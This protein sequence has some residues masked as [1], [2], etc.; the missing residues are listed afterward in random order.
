MMVPPL[1][2]PPSSW[3]DPRR[4]MV[5]FRKRREFLD[6]VTWC[7]EEPGIEPR[8]RLLAGP[9]GTGKTRTALEL[10][11]E[12]QPHGWIVHLLEEPY[13]AI[14]VV[15]QSIG[16]CTKPCL[17]I[18][19]NAD[20]SPSS[21]RRV[22]EALSEQGDT[23][24]R[25]LLIAR[26]AAV[27]WE[28]LTV[29]GPGAELLDPHPI[30][31]RHL[32]AEYAT[33]MARAA[34]SAVTAGLGREVAVERAPTPVA[35]DRSTS[36]LHA[37]TSGVV[38]ALGPTRT[39]GPAE[40]LRLADPIDALLTL[41]RR[42]LTKSAA[43]RHVTLPDDPAA[44]DLLL[45]VAWLTPRRD[46][47]LAVTLPYRIENSLLHVD[48]LARL[49]AE[50]YPDAGPR[51]HDFE[52]SLLRER[53]LE[54]LL[55]TSPHPHT[56]Q[57]IMQTLA[58]DRRHA[59]ARAVTLLS[60]LLLHQETAPPAR[61]IADMGELIRA[62]P[63][64]VVAAAVEVAVANP[65]TSRIR[66]HITLLLRS[67]P[68]HSLLALDSTIDSL[69]RTHPPAAMT[70]VQQLT[71]AWETTGIGSEPSDRPRAVRLLNRIGIGLSEAGQVADALA[72]ARMA[73]TLVTDMQMT[74]EQDHLL[75][76][77]TF[78]LLSYRLSEMLLGK[79][80]LAA[81]ERALATFDP[82]QDEALE[83]AHLVKRVEIERS[84][85]MRLLNLG[86]HEDALQWC[87]A[88]V[89]R[90]EGITGRHPIDRSRHELAAAMT[91]LSVALSENGAYADGYLM[92]LQA[93]SIRRTLTTRNPNAFLPDHAIAL[94]NLG[95]R[96]SEMGNLRQAL[97]TTEEAVS[98]W[99]RLAT[100]QP[101]TFEPELAAALNS[102]SLRLAENG[103]ETGAED[104][105]REAERIWR[106][107]AHNAPTYRPYLAVSL[108]TLAARQRAQGDSGGAYTTLEEAIQIWRSAGD[109]Q[110]PRFTRRLAAA[111]QNASIYLSESG[112]PEKAFAS[113]RE[114][115]RIWESA[116]NQSRVHRAGLAS[117]MVTYSMRAAELGH[118]EEAVDTITRAVRIWSVLADRI[119]A[120]RG[121]YAT[122][123]HNLAIQM[124]QVGRTD[125]AISAAEEAVEI[126]QQLAGQYAEVYNLKLSSAR[127]LCGALLATV[128]PD[129]AEQEISEAHHLVEGISARRARQNPRKLQS[130]R[131]VVQQLAG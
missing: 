32:T 46:T 122:A 118:Q 89:R 113:A 47:D 100:L 36:M 106:R 80:A 112:D 128:D 82:L 13:E 14:E 98:A 28:H 102:L 91:D 39:P 31:F 59:S 85:G 107:V 109:K 37:Q 86:R 52:P 104:A 88:A 35:L 90:A 55:L 53:L 130:I 62:D 127:V 42:H 40:L 77:D 114:S 9:A 101:E 115:V 105:A 117:A 84:H 60:S 74:N 21:I 95:L 96:L 92:A 121:D 103:D 110:A 75:V 5:D 30:W 23:P 51:S 17:I 34:F 111:L 129:R 78:K 1:P 68:V 15:G 38:A 120:H 71:N 16:Q 65:K 76:A 124:A 12:L 25:I 18:V 8:V 73:A 67:C 64:R 2:P 49:L 54:D 93:V 123:L 58:R 94:S 72:S 43:V 26:S 45:L 50:L 61:F 131:Q 79:E 87:Q 6:L 20:R 22:M 33:E 63:D 119:P 24:L 66:E 27:W 11:Q 125:D 57:W 10:Q 97:A 126:F 56:L 83:Y 81:S 99:R 29:R 70:V 69:A 4:R 108:S 48:G 3:I 19:D 41:E 116:A 44:V 7:T